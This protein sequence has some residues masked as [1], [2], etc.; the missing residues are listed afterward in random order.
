MYP[1]L[2]RCRLTTMSNAMRYDG[3]MSAFEV[4]SHHRSLEQVLAAAWS[5]GTDISDIIIQDEYTHDVIV[6]LP[7]GWLVYDTT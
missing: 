2:W 1:S 5:W 7:N 3:E 6:P 4:A